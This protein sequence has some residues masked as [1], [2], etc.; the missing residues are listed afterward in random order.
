MKN[1]TNQPVR[2]NSK[3][4]NRNSA[5]LASGR[6]TAVSTWLPRV[7]SMKKAIAAAMPRCLA[8]GKYLDK[9]FITGLLKT[10]RSSN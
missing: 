9:A 4:P 6:E 2:F 7:S 3:P 1:I 8:D 10:A 5:R